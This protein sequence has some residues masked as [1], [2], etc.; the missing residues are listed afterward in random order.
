[1]AFLEIEQQNKTIIKNETEDMHTTLIGKLYDVNNS[2]RTA[3]I[4][5]LQKTIR[6]LKNDIFQTVPPDLTNVP[7]L[8]IF[9]SSYFEIYTPYS[10]GDKVLIAIMERPYYEAFASD[11][12]SEQQSFGR[13]ELGYAV[14]LRALPN[15]IINENQ[16]SSEKI[17]INN[18]KDGTIILLGKNIE[19]TG[20]TFL[21]GNLEINGD[22]KVNGKL[23]SNEIDTN[24]GVSKNGTPY[25]HP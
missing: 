17:I 22:V 20:N 6:T 14:V 18:K 10:N 15:D 19:I 5:F 16:S 11:E 23:K 9:S 21:N 25:I 4:K 2:K 13:M 3:S 24:N 7:L 1:M 12:I 8:P